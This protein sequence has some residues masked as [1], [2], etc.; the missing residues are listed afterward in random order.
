MTKI[1]IAWPKYTKAIDE[2]ADHFKDDKFDVIIGLTR[3][4]LIPAV[5][6]SHIMDTPML[7][8]NPHMLHTNGDPRGKVKIPISPAVVRRILIVDDIADTGKTFVKC[9]K[10][11]ENRGFNV[12]TTAVYINKKTT[13]FTPTYTVYDSQK[14]WVVFHMKWSNL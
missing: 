3:G 10:F 8:F 14:R 12:S 5:R 4:G 6:L 2:I 7:P 13:V 11:F 1:K 9:V